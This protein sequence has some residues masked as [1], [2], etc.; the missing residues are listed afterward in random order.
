VTR[1]PEIATRI[2]LG[3]SRSVIVRQLLAESVVLAAC[4][5][6]G[7]LAVGFLASRLLASW[8]TDAF[9]VTRR[10]PDA[11]ALAITGGLALLTSVAFGLLPALQV[12]RVDLRRAL[13]ESGGTSV[14]GGAR[15]W[16]RQVIVTP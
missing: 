13:V 1:A 6:A 8:L 7:G 14:A 5:G 10:D 11:R 15:S 2:A 12:S 9:G 16:P 4:G 3:C